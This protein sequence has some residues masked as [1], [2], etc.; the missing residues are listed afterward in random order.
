METS[1][2]KGI[3]QDGQWNGMNK[4]KVDLAN[5]KQLTFFAKGEFK[6]AVGEDI[7]YEITNAQ[8][9]NAKLVYAQ[10]NTYQANTYQ[11]PAQGSIAKED[12][13]MAIIKQTCIKSACEFNA[14]RSNVDI[15]N[16]IN[17]AEV[18]LNWVL[19]K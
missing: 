13:Q 18:M 5:G 4:F 10:Q 16:V 11:K 14:Q 12:I 15:T 7:N 3:V 6:G 1:K 17:D 2:V 8:Y 9:N 19:N